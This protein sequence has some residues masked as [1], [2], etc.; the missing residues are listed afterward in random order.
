MVLLGEHVNNSGTI[1]TPDGQTILAAGDSAYLYAQPTPQMRGLSVDVLIDPNTNNINVNPLADS[2]AGTATNAGIITV[3]EGNATMDGAHLVQNGVIDALTGVNS[4]GSIILTARYAPDTSEAEAQVNSNN[5][6]VYIAPTIPGSITFGPYSVT[7]VLPDLSDPTTTLDAQG[8]NPSVIVVQGKNVT[9]E[10]ASFATAPLDGTD[11]QAIAPGALLMAPGGT[12]SVTAPVSYSLV[13][14]GSA[15]ATAY[16][17]TNKNTFLPVYQAD[18]TGTAATGASILIDNGATIDVSGTQDVSIPVS[19]NVVAVNLRANELAD[20]PLQR[21]GPLY[22]QTVYVDITETGQNAD[23]STWY[24]TPF[25]NASGY[26]ADIGRT[27]AERTA[28]GGEINLISGGSV[29]A[30]NGSTMNV[31]GGWIDYQGGVVATTLLLG[32]DGHLYDISDAEPSITYVG[33][34]GT[35]S[36]AHPR[37]GVTEVFNTPLVGSTDQQYESSYLD[38]RSAGSIAITANQMVLDGTMLGNSVSGP[39]QRTI[40]ANVDSSVPL[41]GSLT[42]Q[43]PP[44]TSNLIAYMEPTEEG[45]TFVVDHANLTP[46][47]VIA[48]ASGTVS[49]SDPSIDRDQTLLLPVDLFSAGGF[50]TLSTE[51]SSEVTTS[52]TVTSITSVSPFVG[53][54]LLPEGVNL[55]FGTAASATLNFNYDGTVAR[56]SDGTLSTVSINQN[57]SANVTID[58]YGSVDLEGSITA[59]AGKIVFNAGVLYDWK[60]INRCLLPGE[61]TID[62][63][64]INRRVGPDFQSSRPLDK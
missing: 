7:Q 39:R 64:W 24:G 10:G 9:F 29:V 40:N 60:A 49:L 28:V 53:T 51:A 11:G 63:S 5:N 19:R 26:I 36:I 62:Y 41:G 45:L 54:A 12:V 13:T 25:A 30:V 14:A 33:I 16:N 4:N 58:T 1:Y 55:N 21:N 47:Q 2:T 46:A 34:A 48:L 20:S 57:N 27:V 61:S 31:S 43:A 22:G 8:F 35:I 38:G 6:S 50:T 44:D 18:T 23:G 59:P 15:Y 42:L 17:I 32:T 56:N 37:W 3:G 52:A